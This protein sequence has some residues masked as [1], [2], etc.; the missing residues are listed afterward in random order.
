MY[1]DDATPLA[2]VICASC[3]LNSSRAGPNTACA[4]DA[5]QTDT[6]AMRT[7]NTRIRMVL[8]ALE[9]DPAIARRPRK[10]GANA[11][12]VL[13]SWSLGFGYRTRR[14]EAGMP[15]VSKASAAKQQDIGVGH[16][17]RRGR[18]GLRDQLPRY[19]R[20]ERHGA[21]PEGAPGRPVPV[22]ALGLRD[23]RAR[24]PSRSPTTPRRSRQATRS[25]S[26][27]ATRRR[28]T[29]DT[30]WHLVQPGRA[31]PPR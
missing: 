12:C 20:G 14:E 3:R 26:S 23:R 30:E 16:V 9:D 29:A 22:P 24:S 17:S 27:P 19:P 7:S 11:S 2:S 21:V 31:D 28:A 8:P 4:G 1:A 5:V 13:T 25:T 15:K 18:R 10:D 6:S